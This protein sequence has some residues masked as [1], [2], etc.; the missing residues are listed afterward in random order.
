MEKKKIPV[1]SYK[2]V[3]GISRFYIKDKF[4]KKKIESADSIRKNE[5]LS[6][7]S[8]LIKFSDKEILSLK[9]KKGQYR[10]FLIQI[11]PF[12]KKLIVDVGKCPIATFE[13][14]IEPEI[15]KYRKERIK[16]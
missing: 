16:S 2:K 1:K 8:Y 9:E 5:N 11:D 14:Y 13:K 10:F 6:H 3:P 12:G 4:W 7:P 15:E